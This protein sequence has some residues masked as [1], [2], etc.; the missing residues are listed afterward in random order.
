MDETVY[1]GDFLTS[2]EVADLKKFFLVQCG[3]SRKA[4]QLFNEAR[5]AMGIE[6]LERF[7][8]EDLEDFKAYASQPEEDGGESRGEQVANLI[9]ARN[10][11]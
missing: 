3:S 10:G 6:D 7:P 4:R 11:R 2:V 8:R 5:R 1:D 9:R